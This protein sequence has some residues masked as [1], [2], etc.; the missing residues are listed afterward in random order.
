MLQPLL[1][2]W[3]YLIQEIKSIKMLGVDGNLEW[4]MTDDAL[5]IKTPEER[6]CKHAFVF[7]IERNL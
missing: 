1:L 7:K 2:I 3:A 4:E 6:P 5:V